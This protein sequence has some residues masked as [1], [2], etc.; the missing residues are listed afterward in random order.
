RKRPDA[1]LPILS[2]IAHRPGA[3]TRF[4]DGASALQITEFQ[5]PFLKYSSEQAIAIHMAP[6][7]QKLLAWNGTPG[8]NQK[9]FGTGAL[10]IPT[11]LD[12]ISQGQQPPNCLIIVGSPVQ[13]VV[14]NAPAT[15]VP[16]YLKN[17]NV[18][19]SAQILKDTRVYFLFPDEDMS[20]WSDGTEVRL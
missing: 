6:L 9:V 18:L 17:G 2:F 3:Q 5:V 11:L 16:H 1:L 4:Y 13:D 12:R 19:Q 14:T 20:R 8:P 10:A 15:L 7:V